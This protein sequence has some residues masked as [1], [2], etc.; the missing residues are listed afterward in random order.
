M[1]ECPICKAGSFDDAEVCYGCLHRFEPG[2]GAKAAAA[3]P[4]G[5]TLPPAAV[6]SKPVQ[7]G[8]MSPISAA[9]VAPSMAQTTST[10]ATSAPVGVSQS[11][12]TSAPAGVS[13]SPATQVM[14]VPAVA[15]AQPGVAA[16]ISTANKPVT[17]KAV[18][19][20]KPQNVQT[21][22]VPANAKGADIVVRIELL[23]TRESEAVYSSRVDAA[24]KAR[25]CAKLRQ[26]GVPGAKLEV[27]YPAAEQTSIAQQSESGAYESRSRHAR[28]VSSA[29]SAAVP[30]HAQTHEREACAV[31]A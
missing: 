14:Q 3:A 6:T 13:Q 12:A 18:A 24:L 17:V 30:R 19:A 26:G 25:A 20:D 5:P 9:S 16:A 31:G 8:T 22:S 4:T 2:E 23:D 27:K 15:V 28:S 10:R 21:I 7:S 11:P 29:R 1:K